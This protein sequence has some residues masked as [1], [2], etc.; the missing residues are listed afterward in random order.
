M[1]I[2]AAAFALAAIQ[3]TGADVRIADQFYD[4]ASARWIGAN[5]W[6]ASTLLHDGGRWMMRAIAFASLLTWAVG[7]WFGA[8]HRLRKAAAFLALNIVV[9]TT[10]VGLLKAVTNVDCPWDLARYGGEMPMLAWFAARPSELPH[11][12]CFPGAHSASGFSL[13]CLYFLLGP[14]HSR[15]RWIGLGFGLA[16]G[17]TF[18]FAQQA[19]GA[20]FLS[21]D[22][23]SAGICWLVAVALHLAFR[24]E[25]L[26]WGIS[27]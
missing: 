3:Y 19:R 8:S 25:G 27:S 17:A 20:H 23:M 18:S 12:Q 16:V 1:P 13:M 10:L 26:P 21:H 15:K 11:A 24:R 7:H 9:S 2:V 5:T 22:V 14:P 4:A 6:W